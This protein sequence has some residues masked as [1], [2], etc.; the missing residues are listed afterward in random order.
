VGVALGFSAS[1]THFDPQAALAFAWDGDLD[2]SFDDAVGSAATFTPAAAGP[3][4]VAVR[5]TDPDGRADVAH[6]VID[7]AAAA[8]RPPTFASLSPADAAPWAAV[9]DSIG[10]AAVASDPD[11]GPVSIAWQLDGVPSG[12]GGSFLFTMPDELPHQVR[13]VASDSDPF[14]PDAMATFTVRAS[15]WLG[16]PPDGGAG[17]PGAA[18][19]AGA[20]A[21][22]G[23]GGAAD[24]G[25]PGDGGGGE[26]GAAAGAGA[27]GGAGAAGRAGAGGSAEAGGA[28]AAGAGA[29]GGTHAAAPSS[30][31]DGGCGC[32][33]GRSRG[34]AG[35]PLLLACVL[36]LGFARASTGRTVAVL[37]RRVNSARG[38]SLRARRR[39]GRA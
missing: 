12:S 13:A 19:A 20:A 38:A 29:S 7:V 34:S 37:R 28:G 24:G 2:G 30:S 35:A 26:A 39:L 27:G 16:A 18:G 4:L 25:G 21:S 3:M 6:A 10:F 15:R 31:G 5:V 1:A 36:V 14:T 22:G 33:T 17:A 9:G 23:A 11:S 32:R 8:N